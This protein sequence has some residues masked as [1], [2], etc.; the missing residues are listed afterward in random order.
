M[1]PAKKDFRRAESCYREAIRVRPD[2]EP[3]RRHLANLLAAVGEGDV[4]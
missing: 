3:A 1:A 2:F 4:R